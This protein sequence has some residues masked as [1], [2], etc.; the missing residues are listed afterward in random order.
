MR[1]F[2]LFMRVTLLMLFLL[3]SVGCSAKQEAPGPIQERKSYQRFFY[4][5]EKINPKFSVH[6]LLLADYGDIEIVLND[7]S[8]AYDEY[9]QKHKEFYSHDEV[10]MRT[11]RPRWTGVVGANGYSGFISG[12]DM[13][14]FSTIRLIEEFGEDF[15]ERSS[16]YSGRS[17]AIPVFAPDFS[18]I[19]DYVVLEID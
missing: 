11:Y 6:E 3:L 5:E 17:K 16:E 10:S 19:I 9:L 13:D 7:Y 14:W 8:A 18:E 15:N 12:V 4:E 1:T 2:K